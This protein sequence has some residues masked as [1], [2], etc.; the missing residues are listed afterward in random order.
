MKM[1]EGQITEH[2][3]KRYNPSVVILYGSRI[4][5]DYLRN[6]D[7]DLFLFCKSCHIGTLCSWKG[8]TLDLTFERWPKSEGSTIRSSDKPLHPVKVLFDATKGE[9]A[10]ILENT[11]AA[12][13]AGPM[14]DC[15]AACVER[16][17]KLKRWEAKILKYRAAPEIIFFYAG[18][19]Y[20]LV[21]RVW[22]EQRNLWPHSP[23]DAL[24]FLERKDPVLRRLLGQF[25][26]SS[27]KQQAELTVQVMKRLNT[28]GPRS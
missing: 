12:F 17:Q 1:N 26:R 14:K 3:L 21:L 27:G 23:A 28:R 10:R 18:C 5:R 22:F 24:K 6:S 4:R 9:F 16:L 8:E 13:K 11:E 20:P 2:L 25:V 7:W 19:F 15:K